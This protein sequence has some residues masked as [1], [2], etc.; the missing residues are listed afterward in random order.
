MICKLFVTNVCVILQ[1]K[2][3]TNQLCK[4]TKSFSKVNIQKRWWLI[5]WSA[6]ASSFSI[7]QAVWD[8]IWR[9]LL[10]PSW[11][12]PFSKLLSLCFPANDG[13]PSECFLFPFEGLERF[14]SQISGKLEMFWFGL[15][16]M[17]RL[18]LRR[19][20][21]HVFFRF[22][23]ERQMDASLLHGIC[24]PSSGNRSEDTLKNCFSF[25]F[26]TRKWIKIISS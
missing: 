7:Y 17:T 25:D 24:T 12:S 14:V 5:F 4:R 23:P 6:E 2:G 9:L 11:P 21:I 16:M 26:V 1:M 15:F 3:N 13:K 22:A 20:D 18:G 19:H 8:F 10:W